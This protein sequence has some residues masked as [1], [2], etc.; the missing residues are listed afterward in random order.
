MSKEKLEKLIKKQKGYMTTQ[1]AKNEGIHREY[2]SLFIEEEKLIR[3]SPGIYQSPEVW[4]DKYYNIQKKKKKMLYSHETA[5]FLHGYSDR[6]P[7]RYSVTL[8]TGYNTSQ[9]K[10]NE[11]ITYSIKPSLLELG[12]IT[13]KSPYEN[14]IY[15]YD[16]ER[17]IC[18]I[19][20]SRNKIDKQIFNYGLKQYV[21]D[22]E[23]DL[24][25]LMKYA[26]KMGIENVVRNYMEILL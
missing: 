5:L 26:N 25:K 22:K 16:K 12:K 19:I 1:D 15:T 2:L 10:N 8:P 4:E 18:D 13:V 9:I 7:I 14:D 20:R 17:T 23:K 24:I 6:D 11:I 3:T 21:N